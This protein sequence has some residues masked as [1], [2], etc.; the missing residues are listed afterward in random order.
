MVRPLPPQRDGLRHAA[1]PAV[2]RP[3]DGSAP[4]PR[5]GVTRGYCGDGPGFRFGFCGGPYTSVLTYFRPES[6][7]SVTT[8]ASGPSRS[9]RRIA[10]PTLA[11]EDVPANSASSRA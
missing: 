3:A 1:A 11:P 5:A 2:R 7:I 8:L 10:A 4:G 6:A 9:A